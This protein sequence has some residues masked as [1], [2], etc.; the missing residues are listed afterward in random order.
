MD[1]LY[2]VSPVLNALQARRRPSF[3]ELM[4]QERNGDHKTSPEVEAIMR[5]ARELNVTTMAL[6]KHDLNMLA[7]NRP[8]QGVVLS[9]APLALEHLG[10]LPLAGAGSPCW[11]ALD[12]VMDPQNLGALVR[13]ASFLGAAGVVVCAKNSAA[14]SP[15]VSKASSGAIERLPVHATRSMPRFLEQSAVNGWRVVGTSLGDDSIPLGDLPVGPPT[16]LVRSCCT[17]GHS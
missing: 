13:S 17:R 5:L 16:V 6:S 1:F 3:G 11:L 12:E 14:P 8:H 2:G 15:V 7:E 9:A 4:I 10:A